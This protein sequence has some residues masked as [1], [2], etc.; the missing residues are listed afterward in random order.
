M[1]KKYQQIHF[2]GIGGIGMS[3]IAR[4]LLNLGYRVTGSDL[5]ISDATRTLSKLGAKIYKG[6]DKRNVEDANVVVVS[7]AVQ[8]TNPEV[9]EAFRCGISVVPRA[10]MLA[11]LMRLKYGVAVAGSHGKTSTTSLVGC[12]MDQAGMDPTLI[13]GGRVNSLRSNA[14]LGKGDFLVAEA[15][16]SDRSFLKLSPTVAIVTNIDREHMEN[17]KDFD[18]LKRSFVEFSNKVPFYGAVIACSAHPVVREIL[19][20]ITRTCVTYGGKGADYTASAIKQNG[21]DLSFDVVCHGINQGRVKLKMV[22]NHYVMNALATIA[23]CRHLDIPFKEIQ[24]ALGKFRGVSRRFEILK[25]NG[26]IIVDDYAHHPVEIAATLDA[27]RS[28]WP[29]KRIVAVMQPHRF[30]R[31]SMHFDSFVS[32]VG[33]ADAAVIMDVYPA[34]EKPNRIYTGE[35]LWKEV[36][37]KFPRKMVAF[38]PTEEEV[39]ATL[40]PWCR[41][42]DLILF[43]GAGSVTKTARTFARSLTLGR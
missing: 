15:D 10:E 34:G 21:E 11:E 38:A 17:Y 26:P 39:M 4:V 18:D 28:A 6:H 22:G 5:K 23:A 40:R 9:R 3:G 43:L 41:R 36:C 19:P 8:N 16:E 37:R 1:F 13:I 12:V 31:L 32:V 2:V 30:S 35:K 20:S 33:G 27:A 7:S 24:S 29:K 25:K 42:E 14:R